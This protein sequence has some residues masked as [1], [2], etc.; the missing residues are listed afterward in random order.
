MSQ[1]HAAVGSQTGP[2]PFPQYMSVYAS[3]QMGVW[4]VVD[5]TLADT[6]NHLKANADMK[7]LPLID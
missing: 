6:Y 5:G 3:L 7:V 1:P 4:L 2:S